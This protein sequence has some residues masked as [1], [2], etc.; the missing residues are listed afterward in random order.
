MSPFLH[1]SLTNTVLL[2]REGW[3][4]EGRILRVEAHR[5]FNQWKFTKEE[6]VPVISFD[7]GWQWIPNIGA[8]RV[9]TEAWGSE[10]DGWIGRRM[11]IYLHPVA[12][13]ELVSGRLVERL[14]KRVEP[15]A[16]GRA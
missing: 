12:R 9:L 4:Y 5:V 10:T 3:R 13:T 7:D 6:I 15:L 14:E 16:D 11:A 2:T 1:H 8:R